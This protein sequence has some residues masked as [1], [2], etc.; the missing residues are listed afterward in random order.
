METS[1]GLKILVNNDYINIKMSTIPKKSNNINK[2][3]GDKENGI[4]LFD[5]EV[6]CE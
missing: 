2:T 3:N 4:I 5:E 6:E 1:E